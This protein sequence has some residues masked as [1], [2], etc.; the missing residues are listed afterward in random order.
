LENKID[1]VEYMVRFYKIDSQIQECEKKLKS[2]FNKLKLFKLNSR[3]KEF[4]ILIK[5]LFNNMRVLKLNDQLR[6]EYEI[7]EKSLIN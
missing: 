6:T 5:H 3:L 1:V 7:S 4:A 2:D